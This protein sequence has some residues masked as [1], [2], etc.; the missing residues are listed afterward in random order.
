MS[1]LYKNS[2][3]DYY[4][5]QYSNDDSGGATYSCTGS[6]PNITSPTALI[7]LSY[8][9]VPSADTDLDQYW[10]SHIRFLI[11]DPVIPLNNATLDF[12]VTALEG[13]VD[14]SGP[15]GVSVA[16]SSDI[17]LDS[18]MYGYDGVDL[19]SGTRYEISSFTGEVSWPSYCTVIDRPSDL[20]FMDITLDKVGDYSVDVMKILPEGMFGN[21]STEK[22]MIL[23]LFGGDKFSLCTPTIQIPYTKVLLNLS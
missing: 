21:T 2:L 6:I 9:G 11:N 23:M 8:Y 10:W 15:V 13:L 22:I 1:A 18:L 3:I 7:H 16:F 5:F 14:C 12:T 17:S 4:R 19:Y 20:E